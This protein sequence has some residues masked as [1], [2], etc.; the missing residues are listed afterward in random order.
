MGTVSEEGVLA[1]FQGK[2]L[3]KFNNS[4]VSLR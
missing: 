1:D 2:E 3:S 4:R